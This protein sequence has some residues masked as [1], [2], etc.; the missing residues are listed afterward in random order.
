MLNNYN[1]TYMNKLPLNHQI[2]EQSLI[3][4]LIFW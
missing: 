4:Q 2:E 3:N 1:L